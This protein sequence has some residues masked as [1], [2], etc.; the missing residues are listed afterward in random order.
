MRKKKRNVQNLIAHTHSLASGLKD[1]SQKKPNS[2]KLARKKRQA[3]VSSKAKRQRRHQKREKIAT[4]TIDTAGRWWR[5]RS[6]CRKGLQSG[7]HGDDR[8]K[9]AGQTGSVKGKHQSN[10]D[11]DGR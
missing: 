4:V 11:R 6:Y 7:R 8:L 2:R 5:W 9:L 3:G 1:R 10:S